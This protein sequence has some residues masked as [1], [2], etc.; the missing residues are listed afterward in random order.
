M[1]PRRQMV[2]SAYLKKTALSFCVVLASAGAAAQPISVAEFIADSIDAHPRVREQLH[3]LRQAEQGQTVARGGWYPSLDLTATANKIDGES[4]TFIGSQSVQE[5]DYESDWAELALTQNL[6]NGFA[7]KHSVKHADAS[8][9]SAL[10]QLYDTVDN[11]ALEALKAYVN[12]VR[13]HRLLKLAENN[14]LAHEDTLQK[15]QRRSSS[16]AGRRSQLEQ[17]S[18]RLAKAK[19][20]LIAQRNNLADSLTEAHYVLGRYVAP[21]DFS[22]VVLPPAANRDID[23]LIDEALAEHP[24]M[25]AADTNIEAATHESEKAKSRFYPKLDLRLAQE[26]GND[27]NGLPGDT[28]EASI[29]LTLTYNFFNGGADRA[30]SRRKVSAV[31]EQQQLAARVRRQVINTLRLAWTAQSHL[32]EQ[33]EYLQDYV[34]QAQK[35]MTSYQEEFFIGQ[36]ELIDLLDAK[37]EVNSAQN[38]Y[39]AA[40]FDEVTARYRVLE[41]TGQLLETLGMA[42]VIGR[43][44]LRIAKIDSRGRDRLPLPM[45]RDDDRKTDRTDH[46]DNSHSQVAVN[47]YGCR[48]QNQQNQVPNAGADAFTVGQN[49]IIEIPL[50]TLFAND[51]DA[52]GDVLKLAGF[53]QPENGMI[54]KNAAGN[55]VYRAKEGFVGRDLFTYLASDGKSSSKG[56]VAL[57][58]VPN[59]TIDFTKVYYVNYVYAKTTLTGP[60][61]D[62]A[63]QIIEAL[64]DNP[65][66]D[67]RIDAYTDNIGSDGFNAALSIKRA[68]GTRQMLLNAGIAATR[69]S[70]FGGGESNPL[71]DNSSDEGRAINRRGEFRFT[72]VR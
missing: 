29:A 49:G 8:F 17:A 20:G 56:R 14:V 72:R 7:T 52:D 40:Y 39:I 54:E 62:L 53:T 27:L 26:V 45:D 57:D 3:I 46:C 5:N 2:R 50:A 48:A 28:D 35:T 6:F 13:D 21:E 24:A 69:I 70:F 41:A 31:H 34:D 67:V 32:G 25:R 55:L 36:R 42:P 68:S 23:A 33:V 15:I 44:R 9:Q 64:K 63:N 16:G 61:V 19:A 43:D 59:T 4:P 37:N 66:I 38:G 1:R 30:E 60:S 71:A 47:K 18:G 12:V 51:T 10:Y 58:V 11:V 65:G 22:D